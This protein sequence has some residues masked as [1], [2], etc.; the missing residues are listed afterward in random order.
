M[1]YKVYSKKQ[2][3][4]AFRIYAKAPRNKKLQPSINHVAK[5]TG[6]ARKT[7]QRWRD[8]YNW[9]VRLSEVEAEVEKEID[10]E[11]KD[12]EVEFLRKLKRFRDERLDL[13]LE[14]TPEYPSIYEVIATDKHLSVR[15]GKPDSHMQL[16]GDTL[17]AELRGLRKHPKLLKK[18]GAICNAE[19]E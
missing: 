13:V 7:I 3:E 16:T 5:K 9:D 14:F 17:P 6:Y 2:I 11:I 8:K 18:L 10:G 4:R 19:E 15:Q 1:G 12:E